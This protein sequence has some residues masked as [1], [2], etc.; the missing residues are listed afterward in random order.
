MD[1]DS[2]ELIWLG[3][4][5]PTIYDVSMH[6]FYLAPTPGS[7]KRVDVINQYAASLQK[8]WECSFGKEHVKQTRTIHRVLQRIMDEYDKYRK[9]NLYGN[10]K[11]GIS[12]KNIRKINKEWYN[13]CINNA[14]ELMKIQGKKGRPSKTLQTD[15]TAIG[16]QTS[17]VVNSYG[18]L[19]IGFNTEN[20][21]GAER[22]FYE[23]QNGDRKFRLSSEIDEDYVK[24][25]EKEYQ[26]KLAQQEEDALNDT[27]SNPCD[28][29]ENI[30]SSSA[31]E[32]AERYLK[33][34]LKDSISTQIEDER[35]ED[36]RR[37]LRNIR[38]FV[39][40]V[41]D[42]IATIGYRCAISVEKARVA[43]QIVCMIW[44]GHMYYLSPEEQQ[45]FEPSTNTEETNAKKPRTADD[46][47]RY[48]YVIPSAKVVGD[49]KHDKALKK[50]ITAAEALGNLEEGTKV[51]LHY[52]TTSRSRVDGEWP[53]LILNFLNDDKLKCKMIPLR[54]LFFAFEDREQIIKLVVETRLS[55]ASGST[56]TAKQLWENITNF[57]TDSVSKNLK[58]EEGV[59]AKLESSHIPYHTLCKS[60]VCEKLDEACIKA[61]TNIET[62]L[63]YPQLIITKQPQLKSFVRQTK[64][65]TLAA[66]KAML[67][68]VAHE[69]SAKPTSLAHDFD[70]QLEED[71]VY[72]SMSLY[73]ERRFTKLGYS[74]A[75]ILDCLP[76]YEKVLEKTSY[77]NLLVQACRLYCQ[78][79]YICAAFKALGYFTYKVTMPFLN[80]VEQCDQNSLLPLL[81]Q[82]HDDLAVGKMNTLQE[83]HVPWTHIKTEILE[84]SSDLD[85]LLLKKMCKGAAEG[86]HMQCASEY[87]EDTDKPRATQLHKLS[88]DERKN[89]P[90]ENLPCERKLSQFGA[91]AGVSA[92][93]SNKF[94]KAKRIRDDLMFD[95]NMTKEDITTTTKKV[96]S[97][98]KCME[99]TWTEDQRKLWKGKIEAA[100]KK[101]SRRENDKEV[102]IARYELLYVI[103]Y[104]IPI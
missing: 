14:K 20:L 102:L 47:A 5:L 44:Y 103:K 7:G 72:K 10:A 33:R 49:H 17:I 92:A 78:S 30:P 42:A 3:D 93:K 21:T 32:R 69:E 15:D 76:Q 56:F 8:V 12:P 16:I 53:C 38:N 28:L 83:Y 74:A 80:C 9:I 97:D 29:A 75:A 18:L 4:K 100:V 6:V 84:P 26:D 48:R 94:F 35:T 59:A 91:L 70:L 58:V 61:L 86:I 66:I 52:D 77:T 79:E 24:E 46:Y 89:I 51:T 65:I 98:L 85:K 101:R 81:K 39:Y 19:D 22:I 87:W 62:E 90:T 23:D 45:K 55:V 64:C 99:L 36:T 82:V 43:F 54:A 60:H 50:E 71:G 96:L 68:I 11:R 57:M 31:P 88:Q 34:C 27:F 41:K 104:L 73:K 40:A 2:P 13:Y 37:E 25:K 1:D 63:N 95:K 67:K